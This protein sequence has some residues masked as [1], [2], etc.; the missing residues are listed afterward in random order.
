MIQGLQRAKIN[1]LTDVLMDDVVKF[2][3]S[4]YSC[5]NFKSGEEIC[6]RWY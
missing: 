6:A 5:H 4:P 3:Y 2:I 1:L